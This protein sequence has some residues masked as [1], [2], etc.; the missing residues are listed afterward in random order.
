MQQ[1]VQE[2]GARRQVRLDALAADPR[3]QQLAGRVHGRLQRPYI[4]SGIIPML[5]YTPAMGGPASDVERVL[6]TVGNIA[7]VTPEERRSNLLDLGWTALYSDEPSATRPHLVNQLGQP[8]E[9]GRH[10]DAE[11][12]WFGAR[13]RMPHTPYRELARRGQRHKDGVAIFCIVRTS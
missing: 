12:P 5:D 10:H 7:G 9:R 11:P 1:A 13:R 2:V 3:M 4:R 8:I 6:E